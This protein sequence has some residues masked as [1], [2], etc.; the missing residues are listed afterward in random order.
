MAASTHKLVMEVTALSQA[1]KINGGKFPDVNAIAQQV[2]DESI[3]S[4]STGG[5]TDEGEEADPADK[6]S[7]F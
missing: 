3:H 6:G 5:G 4:H 1:A 2:L 7:L